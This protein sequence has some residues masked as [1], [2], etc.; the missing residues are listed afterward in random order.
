MSFKAS[1]YLIFDKPKKE[2]DGELLAEFSPWMTTKTFSF[3]GDGQLT[4][5][6][7]D[8]LN[9]YSDLFKVK[10][11][12]FRF[13]ENIIPKQKRKRITYI[14]KAKKEKVEDIPIPEFYSK[15]EIT[16]PSTSAARA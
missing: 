14:K 2:L 7:N 10:E 13:F 15:R 8:T 1:N 11:D 6:I 9:R 4:D 5:Y 12:Q 3:Y 16:K